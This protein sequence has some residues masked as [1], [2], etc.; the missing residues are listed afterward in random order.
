[1]KKYRLIPFTVSIM[2]CIVTL[3]CCILSGCSGDGT[4]DAPSVAETAV[5]AA[6]DS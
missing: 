6:A 4:H 1:M 2:M 5:S 3:V